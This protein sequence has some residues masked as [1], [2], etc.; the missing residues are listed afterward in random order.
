MK[1][2]KVYKIAKEL[3]LATETILNYLEKE[4]KTDISKKIHTPVSEENYQML[5]KHFDRS[6]YDSYM[7]SLNKKP[8]AVKAEKKSVDTRVKELDAILSSKEEDLSKKKEVEK[9]KSS[10]RIK[11]KDLDEKVKEPKEEVSTLKIIKRAKRKEEPEQEK[12]RS[13][14][15]AHKDS[16]SNKTSADQEEVKVITSA[17]E[18]ER[19]KETQKKKVKKKTKSEFSSDQDSASAK[20]HK[21]LKRKKLKKSFNSIEDAESDETEVASKKKKKKKVNQEEVKESVKETLKQMDSAQ[22]KNYKKIKKKKKNDTTGEEIEV[23]VNVVKVTEFIS[24][25]ELAAKFEV[26][27]SDVIA[28]CFGMGLMITINQRLDKETIELIATEYDFEVE[29]EDEYED[30]DIAE[31]VDH[32]DDLSERPPIVTIMG[33]VDHGKTSLLDYIRNSHI[34]AGESGGI[35]QH[36]GAYEVNFQGKHITF[37]DTP[38]HEAFTAM[39]ARGAKV[40]DIVVIVIAST[41]RVMPQTLEAIDHSRAAGVPF[42]IALNKSDLPNAD[43]EKIKMELSQHN[44]LVESWGGKVQDT[45]ISAKKGDNINDLLE[46]ILLEAEMLELKANHTAPARGTVVES[47]L[48][49]GLGSVATVLVY[50]GTLK[51]GDIFVCGQYSGRVRALMNER[52]HKVKEAGPAIPAMVLGFNGTPSAGDIFTVVESEQ[53]ARE[54][55]SKRQQLYR[56]HSQHKVSIVT[57]DHVSEQIKMGEVRELNIILKG[58]VD[59]SIEAISDSIMKLSNE[60]VAVRIIHRS[61]GAITESDILLAKASNAVILG[62]HVRPNTKARE[63]AHNENVEIRQYSIIYDLI[64]DIKQALEG[65]LRPEISEEVIGSVEVRD[66]FKVP[67]IGTIAGCYVLSGSISRNS[68]VKLIRN[69]IEIYDG[70]VSSLKRHKDDAKEVAS[71]FECGVGIERY[72]DIKVGDIIEVYRIKETQR[73]LS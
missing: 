10:R 28:K 30:E 17:E 45:I 33:H 54:I 18:L 44:V 57:L 7:D 43:P 41:D 50:R 38:G 5:I 35:T 59:G 42:I 24:T 1:K 70:K 6:K 52:M 73:T 53:K 19:L 39:R 3:K 37:L 34:V 13:K 27:V 65:M 72:N 36:I 4:L 51:V 63:L 69:D 47:R 40:T 22:K 14:R 48:D 9:T 2:R 21:V 68:K 11:K 60:E 29:F 64:A 23:E 26:D 61:V 8:K 31:E 66:I 71:G 15:D 16:K 58:D 62:F 12:A 46:R 32:E 56:A 20:K 67:K 55:A 25:A 49:K